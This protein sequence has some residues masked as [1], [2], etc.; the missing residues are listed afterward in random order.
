MASFKYYAVVL[1]WIAANIIL[2]AKS[3]I[4]SK[5]EAE[6][7]L[8]TGWWGNTIPVD[9]STSHCKWEGIAC[10]KLG[11]VIGIDLSMKCR[12]L[13]ELFYSD[14]GGELE[15]LNMSSFPN[16]ASLNLSYCGLNGS[17]PY[18]IGRL[19]KLNY[20]QLFGNSLTGTLPLSMANLAQL[21]ELDISY[22]SISGSI[23][24]E[25]GRLSKLN[26]L[27]LSGNQLTGMLPLSMANLTQLLQL[28]ISYNSI[29]GSIPY[30]I[31]R[32]S[33]LNYLQLSYNSLTA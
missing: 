3:S 7:L 6:A 28:G 24:S 14:L 30:E 12:S 27:S 13:N 9:N 29:S 8:R 21:L 5:E 1:V 18:E 31:R 15:K 11:N 23:P 10:N 22:N 2:L 20:L 33:K 17:I 32:L 16:L 4:M 25:I 19:S 26:Y